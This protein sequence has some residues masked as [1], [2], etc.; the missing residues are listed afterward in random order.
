MT[1]DRPALIPPYALTSARGAGGPLVFASPHSG[2]VRPD[3]MRP[4]ADLSEA[5]LCSAEDR[6]VDALIACAPDLGAP[7]LAAQISRTYV[8]L[9]RAPDALDPALI[10]GVAET[11]DPRVRA[12]YG[13][14]PRLTGDGQVIHDRRLTRD[15]AEQ[16]LET[17][18][19]PYH[20]ALAELMQTARAAHGRAALI[21]WHSMP[22]RVGGV[23]V[24]LGD[25]HG[26]SC[27][28][29]LTRQVR[30]L[31]EREGLRVALN[32]PYAG[33]WSTQAWGRPSEGFEALQIELNR[34]LYWDE[35][36][37]RPGVG[38]ARLSGLIGRVI[39]T[40]TEQDW[41]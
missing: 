1:P 27:R 3:D 15:D 18:Y 7:V 21:D 29:T 39:R 10:E 34:A 25:R 26:M 13:V 4:R 38:M 28:T 37:G 22:A 6:G 14:I 9:N 11:I 33:G 36:A 31:F 23:D 2:R 40:L 17:A 16:R 41:R 19:R 30:A 8:D 24:V 20:A 12:G 5:S 35:A 32:H